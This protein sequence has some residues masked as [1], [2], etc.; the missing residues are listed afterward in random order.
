VNRLTLL[1]VYRWLYDE[2]TD[3]PA[4]ILRAHRHGAAADSLAGTQGLH[5]ET[6]GSVYFTARAGCASLRDNDIARWVTPQ[7]GLAEFCP[8]R[9]VEQRETLYLLSKNVAGGTSAAALVSALTTEVRVAAERAGERRGGRI[10][11]P[12][13]LV[14]DEVANICR[15]ADLPEQ[16][17]HLGSR[18]IVPIAILQSYA[19]GDQRRLP[20]LDCT[21]RVSSSAC[22]STRTSGCVSPYLILSIASASRQLASAPPMSPRNSCACARLTNIDG[23]W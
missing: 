16:Y 11:P 2:S 17:S 10:D 15:I 21:S 18:S 9:F 1:D 12:L 13:V 14:L 5:P 4:R 8:G 22:I 23:T 19:Q 7:P 6:R 3:E 20:C